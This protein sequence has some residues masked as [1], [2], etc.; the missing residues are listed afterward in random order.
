VLW[1]P[2][3]HHSRNS[4]VRRQTL[5]TAQVLNWKAMNRDLPNLIHVNFQ[6]WEDYVVSLL[7][8]GW[9]FCLQKGWWKVLILSRMSS[10][11]SWNRPDFLHKNSCIFG[12]L[13]PLLRSLWSYIGP[14]LS[15]FCISPRFIAPCR[16]GNSDFVCRNVRRQLGLLAYM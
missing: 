14:F 2:V 10:I 6:I 11:N 3:L 12:F 15:V 8:L 4:Q 16:P 7:Q 13:L 9:G 5:S 1:N